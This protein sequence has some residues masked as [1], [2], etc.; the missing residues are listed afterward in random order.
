ML[1]DLICLF[2][3]FLNS[4]IYLFLL[5][6]TPTFTT[7]AFNSKILIIIRE[8]AHVFMS[9]LC[10]TQWHIQREDTYWK[11]TYKERTRAQ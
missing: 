3:F 6:T 2:V 11:Y 7:L 9:T 10:D 8:D 4:F 1:I 5:T